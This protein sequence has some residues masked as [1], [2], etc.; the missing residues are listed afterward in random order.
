M[1][2]ALAQARRALGRTFPNPAVGAVVYRG[3]RVLGRGFTQPPGGAHAEIVALERAVR[4]HGPAAL[5]GA[6]L[7]VT[8][9]PCCHQG[10]TGPCTDAVLASGVARVF[11]GHLDPHPEVDGRGVRRLRRAGVAVR[12]GVLA[13]ACREQ[14]RGFLSRI[15]RGRP[16]VTLKL[17]ASLDGRI[18]TER[19]ESRWITGARARAQ[20][21][22]L[23][24]Q[25]DAVMVGSGTA[26]ADDPVL[27]ARRGGRRLDRPVRVLVDSRLRVPPSARLFRGPT[28]RTWVLCSP[29]AAA[30]RRADLRALGVRVLE[31]PARR[32][33][34]VLERALERLGAEGLG[35]LLVE[36]GG[37]LAA[38]LLRAGLVDELLWFAAP[39]LVGAE[40]LPA[41]GPLAVGRL[42]AAPRLAIGRV[43]RF[44]P[45]LLIEAR[46][47]SATA[48]RGAAARSPQRGRGR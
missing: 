45:D 7:A 40:G 38:A 37:G 22:R 29:R 25:S 5:R 11:V 34:L 30:R 18:A 44:D 42:S 24:A 43:R 32:G 23:R 27:L 31:V 20:V 13:D 33:G 3:T 21:H 2:L 48:R 46:W 36:G 6:S 1:R 39:L 14:H 47:S 8:L 15:Q 41:I 16:F 4:R 9:E 35:T 12:V 28:A 19:G 17:A 26:L 10:R